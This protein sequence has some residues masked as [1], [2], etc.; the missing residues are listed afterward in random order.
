VFGIVDDI[1]A[2][3]KL[4]PT[5]IISGGARG[6]DS[7]AESY[8]EAK[9]IPKQIFNAEWDVYGKRAGFLR[10]EQMGK[11]AD[12]LIAIWDSKSRGTKNMIEIMQSLSKKVYIVRV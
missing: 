3:Y 5:L 4:N 12:A 7:L 1:L 11:E 8:A 2:V 6:I 10:N 9:G